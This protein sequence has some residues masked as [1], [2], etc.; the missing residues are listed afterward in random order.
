MTRSSKVHPLPMIA[1]GEHR[2][3]RGSG[4]PCYP[5]R[6]HGGRARRCSLRTPQEPIFRSC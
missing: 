6:G 5:E 1:H 4:D 3:S 2:I